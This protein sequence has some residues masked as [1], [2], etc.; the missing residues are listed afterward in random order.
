[1]LKLQDTGHP[2][3]PSPR[4]LAPSRPHS[5]GPPAS[6]HRAPMLVITDGRHRRTLRSTRNH[7]R[8]A[9]HRVQEYGGAGSRTLLVSQGK[10]AGLAHARPRTRQGLLVSTPR[11]VFTDRLPCFLANGG[12]GLSGHATG[13]VLDPA[14]AAGL[15]WSP[16]PESNRRPHPYHRCAGGSQRRATPHV[17]TQPSRSEMQLRTGTRGGARLRVAQFLANLWQGPSVVV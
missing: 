12:S 1:M 9:V 7:P 6:T 17:T 13:R 5:A 14:W 8:T 2:P 3:P 10:L 16:P 15:W 11:S 4:L